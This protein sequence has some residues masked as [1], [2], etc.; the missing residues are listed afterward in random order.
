MRNICPYCGPSQV[1]MP[2]QL[3]NKGIALS[4]TVLDMPPDGFEQPVLLALVEL[5]KGAVVLALADRA[6]I[7]KVEIDAQVT[8]SRDEAGR[9]LLSL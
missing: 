8:I 3:N 1:M 9:F 2:T 4:Y 5:E 7:E 6:E